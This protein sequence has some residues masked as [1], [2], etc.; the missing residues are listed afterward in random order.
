MTIIYIYK[1]KFML[2]ELL[3]NGPCCCLFD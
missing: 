2:V 1:A 3:L